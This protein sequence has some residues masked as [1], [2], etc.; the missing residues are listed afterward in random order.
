LKLKFLKK[1]F[2]IGEINSTQKHWVCFLNTASI[3]DNNSIQNLNQTQIDGTEN[4]LDNKENNGL[5]YGVLL[6][7]TV[8][9]DW[10]CL[11]EK[12]VEEFAKL[13]DG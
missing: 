7:W 6:D 4:S 12:A 8:F 5:N 10:E 1:W 3:T 9:D 13:E 11:L 2:K